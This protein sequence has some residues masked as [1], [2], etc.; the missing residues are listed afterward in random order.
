LIL[1]AVLCGFLAAI[2]DPWGTRSHGRY[3]MVPVWVL[4]AVILLSYIALGQGV[5]CILMLSPLWL[6]A[7]LIG[8]EVAYRLRHKQRDGRVYCSTLIVVP[9]A[10]MIV[11]SAI[12]LPTEAFTVTRTAI[13]DGTP[14]EL[15]PLVRGIPDVR[16]GE[17]RWNLSQDVIGIPRPISA[18]LV[19][20]GLGS[21]RFAIWQNDIRFREQI[22]EWEQQSRIG[23]RFRFDDIAGFGTTD[24]HLMPDSP[25]FNVVSGGYVL[26]PVDANRTRVTLRTTYRV[27]TPLNG[28]AR[29][30]G[31]LLL[32]DLEDNLLALI[33]QRAQA[34]RKASLDL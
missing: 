4:L 10:A 19:G 12:P 6:I 7:G 23:W 3:L 14:A 16:P 28:Y 33:S 22:V 32:G 29:L 8:A 9:L 25:H 20:D 2:A 15:W 18:R 21:E 11:E 31:E 13:I 24:R 30:W 17:G 34:G 27:T 1:P 26:E 5:I